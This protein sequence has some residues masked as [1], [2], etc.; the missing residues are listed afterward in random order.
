[1]R[2]LLNEKAKERVAYARSK[3]PELP[4][5]VQAQKHAAKLEAARRYRERNRVELCMKARHR[6]LAKFLETHGRGQLQKY[7]SRTR[8]V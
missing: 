2:E 8:K 1:N 6:R 7:R 4:S 5:E 3:L